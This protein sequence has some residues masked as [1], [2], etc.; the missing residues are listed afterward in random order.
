MRN[1]A[2]W[3]SEWSK[4]QLVRKNTGI[5][6][7]LR[8][9]GK[10]HHLPANPFGTL[11][12][13]QENPIVDEHIT[14]AIIYGSPGLGRYQ[15]CCAHATWFRGRS[16]R[17]ERTGAQIR[18]L[19]NGEPSRKFMGPE[20]APTASPITLRHSLN[21]LYVCW[22]KKSPKRYRCG[23]WTPWEY[24]CSALSATDRT[25]MTKELFSD[26]FVPKKLASNHL[27]RFHS[28]RTYSN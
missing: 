28:E 16:R 4:P 17:E 14:I 3:I 5:N 24:C 23:Y 22:G 21:C 9:N 12:F 25:T 7:S 10:R 19:M 20:Q 15:A 8:G 26:I 13:I 27:I 1:F 11:C 6:K 2:P 18:S